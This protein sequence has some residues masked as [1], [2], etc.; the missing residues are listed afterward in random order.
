MQATAIRRSSGTSNALT[1]CRT[2][3]QMP[4]SSPSGGSPNSRVT[5][6]HLGQEVD[7]VV[8]QLSATKVHEGREP[9][10]ARRFGVSPKLMGSLDRNAPSIPLQFLGEH[11][12]EQ[13]G[14]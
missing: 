8:G 1:P 6:G 7:Q 11:L 10:E 14:R 2:G 9:G 12:V 4:P 13:V 5:R 3:N